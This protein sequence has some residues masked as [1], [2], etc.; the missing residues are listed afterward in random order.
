MSDSAARTPLYATHL[1]ANARMVEF[2]GWSMPLQYSSIVKEHKAV[3]TAGGVFDA[4]HMGEV[5][6]RGPAA[7]DAC[8]QLFTSELRK[9]PVGR[10]KYGLMCE[11]SGGVMDDVIV[12]RVE[13]QRYMVCLNAGNV[14]GDLAWINEQA[15]SLCEVEDRSADTALI[16][17]QGPAAATVLGE[18]VEGAA[19]LPRFAC[20][21]ILLEGETAL[22][23]RTGYTGEDGFELFLPSARAEGVWSALAA[24]GRPLG[25]VPAGLGARDTLRLEAGLP[26]YGHELDLDISPLEAGLGRFV[27][28]DIA[29]AIGGEALAAERERG[30]A[31][32][33]L[34]LLPDGAIARQGHDVLAGDR[35]V[36][37]VTSGTH[38]P[39]LGRPVAMALVD[40]KAATAGLSVDVRG[41]IKPADVTV[42]P[43]YVRQ[44]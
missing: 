8:E 30:P 16:A 24:A 20:R 10:A 32:C 21:E 12:Y 25:V 22:M 40:A 2:S 41:R 11:P 1:D 18:L 39:S 31:R 4:S 35:V 17:L 7:I 9:L 23:A 15:G 43:F 6:L 36:G 27:R 5:E 13:D 28:D 34:G 37:R 19:D 44:R 26:L 14:E 33:L 29:T 42:L 38:S 3:R